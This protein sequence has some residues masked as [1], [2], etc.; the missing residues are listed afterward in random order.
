MP[1]ESRLR[2]IGLPGSNPGVI[3]FSASLPQLCTQSFNDT[4]TTKN[5]PR[6]HLIGQSDIPTILIILF[7]MQ[8]Q[9][10]PPPVS[11]E[12][13]ERISRL[14]RDQTLPYLA[15][16][17]IIDL[18]EEDEP[19]EDPKKRK[20]PIL[21]EVA[22]KKRKTSPVLSDSTVREWM[23]ITLDHVEMRDVSIE[24]CYERLTSIF[25]I[26]K[27]VGA[28]EDHKD[29]KGISTGKHYHLAVHATDA[30]KHTATKKIRAIF[31][32]WEGRTQNVA[33][34]RC[35]TTMLVYIAKD[36]PS[37]K[38]HVYGDYD[39]ESGENDI[40]ARKDKTSTAVN[41][42]RKHIDSGGSAHTLARNDDVARFMLTGAASVL[43]FAECIER[44]KPTDTTMEAINKL[45]TD[46]DLVEARAKFSPEQLTALKEFAKQLQGRTHRQQQIY[47]VGPPAVG[48][49]FI[50]ELL[51]RH[52]RCFIPCL[53]NNDRAFASFDD[54]THDWIFINDFH[55]NVRFQLL[56]NL[57]EGSTMQ[58]NGYGCQRRK[59]RNVPVVITANQRPLYKNLDD[60]RRQ[61]LHSR[62]AFH[63]FSTTPPSMETE[64]QDICAMICSHFH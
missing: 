59:T 56:N 49:T 36:G 46:V 26:V 58:L 50:W 64:I 38:D 44:S 27:M 10:L 13:M 54:E 17:V 24:Q 9:E 14:E 25:T 63:E 57:L 8:E 45:G 31:P 43:K 55:D 39:E 53:E 51:S 6:K 4:T 60:T 61:A 16:P 33:F 32:E 62:L 12:V 47:C 2:F 1:G 23:L 3:L 22:P 15:P 48:K 21:V 30:S 37:W 18:C 34:H 5:I 40:K 19:K 41:A 11:R 35:W 42:I 29:D 20:A 7:S 52:T 28:I